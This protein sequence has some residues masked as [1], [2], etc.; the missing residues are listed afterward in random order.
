LTTVQVTRSVWIPPGTWI[1]AWSGTAFTGPQTI[2][3]SADLRTTPIY[4]EAGTIVPLA[5]QMSH[6]GEL[7]WDP[8]A[9]DVYPAGDDSMSA[10]L[11]EDDTVSSAYKTGAFRTTEITGAA[12]SGAHTVTVQIMPAQ[13]TFTGAKSKR[14]WLVRIHKPAGFA[15]GKVASV[16]VDAGKAKWGMVPQD[17]AQ[18]PFEHDGAA[19]DSDV[20]VVT[21]P[22]SDVSKARTVVVTYA[23][24]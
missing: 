9:L 14:G 7:P 15:A 21:V 4:V 20:T 13:G 6:T 17:T 10:V 24:G 11:Y 23:G 12:N 3:A 19:T 16:T 22:S 18:M 2:T 5:P 8:L 1:D